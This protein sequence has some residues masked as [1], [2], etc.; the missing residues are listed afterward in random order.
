M[1]FAV[2]DK[3][4][5]KCLQVIKGYGVSNLCNVFLNNGQTIKYWWNETFE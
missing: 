1:G 5:M 3:H 2:T 4:L